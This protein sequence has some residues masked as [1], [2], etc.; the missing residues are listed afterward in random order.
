ML[1]M[2][3]TSFGV[4]AAVDLLKPDFDCDDDECE[5]AK[6]MEARGVNAVPPERALPGDGDDRQ[7]PTEGEVVVVV[8]E[9]EELE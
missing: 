1:S 7:N 8:G 2:A 3:L 6:E 5:A 4:D 9:D